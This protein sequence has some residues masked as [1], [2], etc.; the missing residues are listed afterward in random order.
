MKQT[1]HTGNTTLEYLSISEGL[2][3][4]KLFKFFGGIGVILW[5]FV[6]CVEGRFMEEERQA[7]LIFSIGGWDWAT[8]EV[9]FEPIISNLT[10]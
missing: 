5:K 6:T 1:K 10:S 9:V 2:T 3:P 7:G 8:A 4:N